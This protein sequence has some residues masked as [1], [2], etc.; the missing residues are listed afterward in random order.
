MADDPNPEPEVTPAEVTEDDLRKLVGEVVE[1][2]L[3]S[4]TEGISGLTDSIVEK[5][6]GDGSSDDSLLEKIGG[7]IDEKLKGLGNGK[8][9][10]SGNGSTEE[11]IPKL[12]IFK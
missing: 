7:M 9:T 6:K 8:P 1:E 12:R 5:L 2:K 10:P 3:S 4:I 11:R